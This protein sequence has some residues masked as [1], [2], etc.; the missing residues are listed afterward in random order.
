VSLFLVILLLQTNQVNSMKTITSAQA[1]TGSETKLPLSINDKINLRSF[2]NERQGIHWTALKRVF[3]FRDA[4]G[5]Q[6][7][8]PGV[9]SGMWH[10]K[11]VVL[12]D[13]SGVIT[14]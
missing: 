14:L 12:K 2:L 13:S 4:F 11:N 1:R 10:T 5:I 7:S 8:I 9:I 3:A 6:Y